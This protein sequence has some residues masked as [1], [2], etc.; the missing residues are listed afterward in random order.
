[1]CGK[2]G[3]L[4]KRTQIQEVLEVVR[5]KANPSVCLEE[6]ILFMTKGVNRK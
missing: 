2:K 4:A 3:Q 6:K 5:G 1:M